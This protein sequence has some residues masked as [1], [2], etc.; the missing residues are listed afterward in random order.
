M[1]EGNQQEES[2]GADAKLQKGRVAIQGY[3]KMPLH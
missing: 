3:P 1:R 2:G